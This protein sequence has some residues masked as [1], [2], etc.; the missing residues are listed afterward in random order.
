[1]GLAQGIHKLLTA[2]ALPD[3]VGKQL[4]NDGV[5]AIF[6]QKYS[7]PHA[8][9]DDV[10]HKEHQ[11]GQRDPATNPIKPFHGYNASKKRKGWP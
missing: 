5:T 10:Q 1:M 11:G 9:D 8:A 2:H 7:M 3:C 6:R 4:F